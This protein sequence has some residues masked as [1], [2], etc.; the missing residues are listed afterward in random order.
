MSWKLRFLL[1]CIGFFVLPFGMTAWRFADWITAS[2]PAA[3][4]D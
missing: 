2:A 4:R 3:E 1:A